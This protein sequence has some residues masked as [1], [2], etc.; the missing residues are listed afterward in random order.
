MEAG[1][2]VKYETDHDGFDGAG[3]S[4]YQSARSEERDGGT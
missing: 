1:A 4:L 2:R 3:Q